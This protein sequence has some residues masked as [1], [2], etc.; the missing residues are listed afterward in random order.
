M[1]HLPFSDTE[2]PQVGLLVKP[3]MLQKYALSINYTNHIQAVCMA[4]TLEYD[5]G[6]K[7]SAK[8]A[9]AYLA[10]LLPIIVDQGITCLYVVDGTYFKQ[11]TGQKKIDP[12]VGYVLDCVI[13]GFEHLKIVYGI[14]HQSVVY[15]PN[16][17]EKLDLSISAVNQVFNGTV[18]TIGTDVIRSSVFPS[19]EEDIR[20]E[21]AKLHEYPEISADIEAFSLKHYDAGVGTISFAT[22]QHD[23]IAFLCDYKPYI[24]GRTLGGLYGRKVPNKAI[25]QELKKFFDSYEGSIRWHGSTYDLKVL[26]FVLYMEEDHLNYKG[27]LEGIHTLTAKFDDTKLIAY[28]SLNSTARN[29]YGLKNLAHAF[30]GDYAQDEITDIRRIPPQ[31]LL[32]YNLYDTLATNYVYNT[33]YPKMVEDKQE[34]IYETIF[35]ES[36]GPILQIELVGMPLS[37]PHVLKA[38]KELRVLKEAALTVMKNSSI[39]PAINSKLQHEAMEAKNAKLKK[40]QHPIEAFRHIVFNPNSNQQVQKLLY[41]IWELPIIDYTKSK[42]PATGAKTLGKLINHTSDPEQIAFLKALIDYSKVDKILTSFIPAFEAAVAKDNGAHFLHGNFVLG[43]TVSGRLSS[44]SPNLQNL[45]SGS[46]YG[47]LIKNCFSPPEGWI[48]GGA[49]FNSL[50][51]YISALTTKDPNKLKVYLDGYDGHCLRAYSYWPEKFTHIPNTVEG[52]NSIKKLH[53]REREDS[54][55]P[56]FSLTYQG[57]YIT[58]MNNSGFSEAEAK[59]IEK[60]FQELYSVSIEWVQSKLDEAANTGYVEC[61]FGLKVRTPLIH[62]SLQTGRKAYEAEAEGRTAGNALG[63]SY[64]LLNNRA[65][66]AF[67]RRVWASEYKYDVMPVALI[68]DAIYLLM[69]NDPKVVKFVND[70]LIE[71]MEWQELPEI[72][73]DKVKLGAEL[74]L[75]YP[76]WANALTLPN[77]ASQEEIERLV[78]NYIKEIENG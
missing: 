49:D 11:L 21:L 63:Q 8:V 9:K 27:M 2:A 30:C 77:R 23:G 55:P 10:E 5:N 31:Q 61:A 17:Q 51:D 18:T 53:N 42:A 68:H 48:F 14:N 74:D 26:I 3:S 44:N 34:E 57:T 36:V 7:V 45:P 43:G 69:R 41:E 13:K 20:L 24:T 78:D 1:Q 65:C 32:T 75:F 60:A 19:T 76:S 47:K 52:I 40:K 71:E 73:H 59:R 22:S 62:Q 16:N 67:M 58:L 50:E 35:K 25:R 4:F 38:Q 37:M 15:N 29:S 54:K 46:T 70:T 39:F 33:Y 64:G 72:V 66:N 6:S 28:L 56:T 12:V